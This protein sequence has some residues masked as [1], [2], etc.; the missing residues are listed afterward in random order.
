MTRRQIFSSSALEPHPELSEAGILE[1]LELHLD[2]LF[3]K[4][5]SLLRM[6]SA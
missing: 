6:A 2:I 3:K 1:K 5:S 4:S